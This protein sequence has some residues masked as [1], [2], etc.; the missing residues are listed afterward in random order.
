MTTA[1]QPWHPIRTERLLLRD[2]VP[3]DFDTVHAYAC[4]PEVARFMDWGPNTPEDT[5]VFLHRALSDQAIWPRLHFGLAIE[6][7][8]TSAVI[9]SIDLRLLHAE[10]R[11]AEIGYCLHRDHWR[12]GIVSEAARALVEVAFNT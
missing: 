7:V 1:P 11:T 10:D 9:G 4:D 12:Q 8:E 2:F 5:H 6:R 3:A